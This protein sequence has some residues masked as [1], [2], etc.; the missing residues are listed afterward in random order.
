MFFSEETSDGTDGLLQASPWKT[1]IQGTQYISV[2]CTCR[3][4]IAFLSHYYCVLQCIRKIDQQGALYSIYLVLI[5]HV[6]A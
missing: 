6:S 2:I 1:V 3:H 5:Q 4:K